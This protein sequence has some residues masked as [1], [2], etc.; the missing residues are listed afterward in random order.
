MSAAVT[1]AAIALA[2]AIPIWEMVDAKSSRRVFERSC[3]RGLSWSRVL[4]NWR[5]E[6][7]AMQCGPG[8]DG[9]AN[10]RLLGKGEK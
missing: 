5:G 2:S 3:R 1:A 8:P 7:T 4:A 9:A 10:Q 6:L